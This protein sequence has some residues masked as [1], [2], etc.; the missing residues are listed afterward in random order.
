ML[1]N[2]WKLQIPGKISICWPEWND[3]GLQEDF[4]L[5]FSME[6]CELASAASLIWNLTEYA[7][8]HTTWFNVDNFVCAKMIQNNTETQNILGS[9]TF[10]QF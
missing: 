1:C 9:I 6:L 3:W 5:I 10:D 4:L 8:C 2:G 7:A